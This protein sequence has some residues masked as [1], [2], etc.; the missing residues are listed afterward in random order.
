MPSNE[1]LPLCP[2]LHSPPAP[3]ALLPI[4]AST[5]LHATGLAYGGLSLAGPSSSPLLLGPAPSVSYASAGLGLPS[6]SLLGPSSS[7]LT[8]LDSGLYPSLSALR[9]RSNAAALGPLRGGQA[10]GLRP[11]LASAPTGAGLAGGVRASSFALIAVSAAA[12]VPV[13][14]CGH[15]S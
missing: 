13:G 14:A 11:G 5:P 2:P 12:E 6:S 3:Q 1:R 7:P 10:A 8:A 4:A 15:A 9:S